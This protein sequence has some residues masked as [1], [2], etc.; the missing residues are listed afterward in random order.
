MSIPEPNMSV[1]S[2]SSSGKKAV[3]MRAP[4]NSFDCGSVVTEFD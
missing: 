4:S 3:L 2:A 1:S